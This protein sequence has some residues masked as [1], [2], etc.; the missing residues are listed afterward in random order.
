MAS[1]TYVGPNMKYIL[2]KYTVDCEHLEHHYSKYII[3]N[4]AYSTGVDVP[5]LQI[6]IYYCKSSHTTYTTQN[7]I[8]S[9]RIKYIHS[10]LRKM[11][12]M[13]VV[14]NNELCSLCYKPDSC[15]MSYCGKIIKFYMKLT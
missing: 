13:K 3:S 15:M 14:D 6:E 4:F 12:Q 8:I 2:Q 7:R 9:L 5:V 11:V 10:R 1:E